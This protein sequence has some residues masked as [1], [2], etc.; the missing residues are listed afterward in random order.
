[1]RKKIFL[2]FI[3]IFIKISF[4]FSQKKIRIISAN[5]LS[6]NKSKD[7]KDFQSL[8]GKVTFLHDSVYMDCD[9]AFYFEKENS[10]IAFGNV[11]ILKGDSLNLYSDS[12]FYDGN[13]K[14]AKIRKN[15]KLIKKDQVTLTTNFLDFDINKNV[16]FYFNGGK[17]I[18]KDNIL[19]SEKGF[20]YNKKNEIFF[21]KKVKIKNPNYEIFSD[22]LKY[23]TNTEISYFIGPTEIFSDSNYIYCEN[24]W[25]EHKLEIAKLSKNV[26]YKNQSKKLK[27][28]SLFFDRKKNIGKAYQNIIIKDTLENIILKSNYAFY[29]E[30]ED[31]IMLTDSALLIQVEN[32]DSL[33]LSSDTLLSIKKN[34]SIGD[35]KILKA[36]HKTKIFRSDF[37]SICDS[38]VYSLRD[39]IIQFFI[40]PVIWSSGNQMTAEKINI[41]MSNQ[42]IKYIEMINSAFIISKEDSIF[43]NQIKGK[44]II[45]NVKDNKLQ[46]IFV[47]GNGE[48]VYFEKEEE[49]IVGVN[50]SESSK[51]T[52]FLNDN[53]IDK[54][55]FI[56][57][58]K[59]TFFPLKDLQEK[60]R[61]LKNFKC[62]EN[63]RPKSKNDF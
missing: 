12:L 36:F 51:M 43:F 59:A 47:N 22:T 6:F 14:I 23:N 54:I 63:L 53:K 58:P 40:E 42:K 19:E 11:H 62:L 39:S 5:S 3:L 45:A 46:K 35:F 56:K 31:Y 1:M 55:K 4:V 10:L 27:S 30:N 9:T 50:K 49:K 15:V 37:Q 44:K 8:T 25:Y 52:I 57:K 24:G 26:I 61:T 32:N 34:D 21:K 18:N 13:S 16:S 38:L 20:Y 2:I 7:G 33:F 28:D 60:E 48:S 17:S 41:K 29:K